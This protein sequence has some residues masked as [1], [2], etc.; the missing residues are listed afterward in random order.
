MYNK[1]KTYTTTTNP[2]PYCWLH[3]KK[4]VA[5][6]LK[7]RVYIENVKKVLPLYFYNFI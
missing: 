7:F 6:F 3:L 4:C 1:M 2:F 5:R